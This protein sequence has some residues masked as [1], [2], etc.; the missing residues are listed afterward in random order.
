MNRLNSK[1]GQALVE[2]A[3]VLPILLLLALGITEFGRAWYYDNALDDAVRA[4][5]RKAS[6]QYPAPTANDPTIT[7]Y[8]VG[9]ITSY[10]PSLAGSFTANNVQVFPPTAANGKLVTVTAS[11]VFS[12]PIL[13]SLNSLVSVFSL[14]DIPT[15]ITLQRTGTMYYELAIP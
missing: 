8:V 1:K 14:G 13:I 7:A 12:E 11:Y 15:S 3:L 9:E 5:V 10:I 2:L 6:E 4:G